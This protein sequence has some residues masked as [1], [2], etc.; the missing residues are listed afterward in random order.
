MHLDVRVVHGRLE[1][2]EAVPV[3]QPCARRLAVDPPQELG[4][5]VTGRRISAV[6]EGVVQAR[7][8]VPGRYL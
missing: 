7:V 4:A 6:G 2:D 5:E 8:I 1:G 3:G